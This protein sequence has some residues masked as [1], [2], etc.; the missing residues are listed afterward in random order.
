MLARVL[1]RAED[2]GV[3]VLAYSID[4]EVRGRGG[5]L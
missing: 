1:R 5:R 4:W 3:A 2:A